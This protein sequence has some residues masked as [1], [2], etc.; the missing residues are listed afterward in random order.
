MLIVAAMTGASAWIMRDVTN[1]LIGSK[2]INKIYLI[3]LAVASIFIIKGLATYAQSLY[4]SRA[5]NSIIAERQTK[6]LSTTSAWISF[7]Y[8]DDG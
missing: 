3:A 5:G 7:H 6:S 1:E 8:D 2:D 4:L